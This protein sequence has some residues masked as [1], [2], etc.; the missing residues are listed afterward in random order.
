MHVQDIE[1]RDIILSIGTNKALISLP[2]DAADL[3]EKAVF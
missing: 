2:S 3:Y 1:T